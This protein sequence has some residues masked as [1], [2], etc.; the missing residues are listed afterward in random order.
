MSDRPSPLLDLSSILRDI[1]DPDLSVRLRTFR[2]FL[3]TEIDKLE[4]ESDRMKLMSSLIGRNDD[5]N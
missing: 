5:G 3:I 2:L 4:N 1:T